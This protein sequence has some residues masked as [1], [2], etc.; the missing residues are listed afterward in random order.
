M[1]APWNNNYSYLETE[2]SPSPKLT[3]APEL[4]IGHY[5]EGFW[6][7]KAEPYYPVPVSSY[8]PV[9]TLFLA[10]LT[11]ILQLD[12]TKTKN[13]SID[14][15]DGSSSCRLCGK[16]NGSR[17]FYCKGREETWEFPDGI[18]HY[19]RDHH[20]QPTRAFQT[21]ITNFVPTFRRVV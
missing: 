8:H 10:R 17:T 13:I 6:Y 18:V 1:F 12:T 11:S 15:F 20:V 5:R 14:H 16:D 7:S 2:R 9:N 4:A 19:A 3:K 21:F